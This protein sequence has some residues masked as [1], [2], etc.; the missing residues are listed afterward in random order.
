MAIKG[1]GRTRGRRAVAA[2]PKRAIVVRKPP[3]WR[4]RWVWLALG[5]AAVVGIVAGILA[6][7]HAHKVSTT[8]NGRRSPRT[9]TSSGST[10]RTIARRSRRT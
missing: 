1:K 8:G 4:R 7:I 3:I 6:A 5:V 10:F 2:P 9:S